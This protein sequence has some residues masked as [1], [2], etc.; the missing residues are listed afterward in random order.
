MTDRLRR[1]SAL[2]AAIVATAIVGI[3]A[4]WPHGGSPAPAPYRPPAAQ[5]VVPGSVFK[6]AVCGTMVTHTFRPRT[7]SA[8]LI[9]RDANVLALPR[10]ANNV[11]QAPP[12][13]S[14]GKTEF[15]WD[16]PTLAPGS[17]HGNVL[18][19]AHT[20][21]DDSAMGNRLLDHLHVGGQIIVRG[22]NAELCYRVTKRFVIEAANG[23]PAYY[24][25]DGP[26]QLALIVCSPPRLGPGDWQNR[27]IWFASPE[28]QAT[29]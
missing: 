14:V 26:P 13:S 17:P 9:A 2:V 27:T 22:K 6:P 12:L 25:K 20:W 8:A 29:S 18:F 4:F 16:E 1:R 21:P 7:I 15:A 5:A 10:D 3:W 19:N 24:A 28:N 11:P 23:S